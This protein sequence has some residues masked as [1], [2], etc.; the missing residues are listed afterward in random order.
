MEIQKGYFKKN[1]AK[2]TVKL[3]NSRQVVLRLLWTRQMKHF[4]VCV[5]N[6]ICYIF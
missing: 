6:I 3:K 1:I 4:F 2:Y 5:K